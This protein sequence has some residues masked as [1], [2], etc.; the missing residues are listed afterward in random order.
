MD[1]F[2]PASLSYSTKYGGGGGR[3][4]GQRQ[5]ANSHLEFAGQDRDSSFG[6]LDDS[7]LSSCITTHT[8]THTHKYIY[9]HTGL[10]DDCGLCSPLSL[11]LSLITRDI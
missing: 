7:G 10:L 2:Y 11:V 3:P 8:H 9:T 1:L 6:L 4:Y 5:G